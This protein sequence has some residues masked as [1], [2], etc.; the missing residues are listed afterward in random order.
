MEFLLAVPPQTNEAFLREVDEELRRDQALDF[1]K[2]YGR[3]LIGVVIG[4]LAVYAG[5]LYWQHL[6]AQR[7]GD[8]GQKFGAL[9]ATL[10]SSNSA[11]AEKP[12]AELA[13]DGTDGYRASAKFVQADLLLQKNDLKGAAAIF[14]EVAGDTSLAQPFREL[15]LIRQT[16]AEYDGM[17]PEAV[18]TRLAPLAVKGGPWFGSAGEMVA[19]AHLRLGHRDQAGKIFGDIAADSTVPEPVRQRAVQMAG[20]LGVDAVKTSEDKKAQ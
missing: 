12:L 14:A 15:A 16:S 9:F 13:A 11:S 20:T 2:R 4:G 3:L 7:A 8:Q 5:I 1:W 19:V 10:G 18:I 6:Q 17:K